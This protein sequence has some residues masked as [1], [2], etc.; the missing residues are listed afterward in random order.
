MVGQTESIHVVKTRNQR[1]ISIDCFYEAVDILYQGWTREEHWG[2]LNEWTNLQLVTTLGHEQYLRISR[3]IIAGVSTD[4]MSAPWNEAAAAAAAAVE[5][6]EDPEALQSVSSQKTETRVDYD[7]IYSPSYQVPVLYLTATPLSGTGPTS[8]AQIYDLLV[9]SQC[10]NQIESMG[11]MG[12]VSMSEHP[13]TGLPVFFVHPCRTAEAMAEVVQ[14][15]GDSL[16]PAE[17]LMMW[18]GLVG[19][20]VGLSMPV[21]LAKTM[22][23]VCAA[24]RE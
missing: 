1:D 18:L 12:A 4:H 6:E 14:G 8:L 20:S 16:S 24:R 9:P 3:I 13:I 11:V 23:S 21:E 7:I 19:P 17:Y 10:R 5:D 22:R 2:E 15:R